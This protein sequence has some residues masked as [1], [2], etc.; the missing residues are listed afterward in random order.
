MTTEKA[1]FGQFWPKTPKMAKNGHFGGFAKK[2]QNLPTFSGR[3]EMAR[4][5]FWTPGVTQG[6][7]KDTFSLV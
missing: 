1:E 5:P 3:P 6:D 7:A 2:G 4:P